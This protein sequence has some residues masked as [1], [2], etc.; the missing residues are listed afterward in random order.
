MKFEDVSVPEIYKSSA[1]FRFFLK[2]F[3]ECLLKIKT[4]TEDFIDLYDPL[5]CPEALLWCLGD[6]MGYKYD[7][8]LPASYNR[9][10]MLYFM[11]MIRLKGSKDGVTLAAEINLAQFPILDKSTLGYTKVNDDG[12]EEVIEPVPILENR[13]EDTSIPVNS[14]FVTPHTSE[15]YIEV[16]YFSTRKPVDACLEYVR[17]VGMYIFGYS[18]VR[19]DARTKVSVDA[20]LTNSNNLHMSIGATHVGHYSREDY[21]RM[22]K[23]SSRNVPDGSHA[24]KPVWYRNSKYEDNRA[25]MYNIDPGY[26]SLY[27]LQLANNEQ[28]V[29]S[30]LKDPDSGKIFSLGYNPVSKGG[31]VTDASMYP[32]GSDRPEWNLRYDAGKDRSISEDTFVN[33][34]ARTSTPTAPKPAVNPIMMSIGDAVEAVDPNTSG[35]KL[36]SK[37]DDE[38][39]ISVNKKS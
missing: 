6:T 37:A 24:R 2:W 28:I 22:Q 7:D 39:N 12:S 35:G 15:G 27:S 30:L 32:E 29:N 11:S 17:P 26:R 8:R 1:D 33:D 31:S 25:D 23:M 19:Y 10:V 18:G 36:Y 14:A 34:P 38:G 21:A 5:R 16:V 4:E 13:L 9:L 3:S 20:R